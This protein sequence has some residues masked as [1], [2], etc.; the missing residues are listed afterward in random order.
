M[1]TKVEVDNQASARALEKA[2]F[3]EVGRMCLVRR[4]RQTRV[5]FSGA[6][7]EIGA[8]LSRRLSR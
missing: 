3:A 2:G 1:I 8:E 4:W 6:H 7:E 5:T